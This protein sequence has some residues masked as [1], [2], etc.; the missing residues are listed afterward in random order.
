MRNS[1][2]KFQDPS[3]HSSKDTAGTK[4]CDKPTNKWME[5]PKG[6]CPINLFKFGR[7]TMTQIQQNGCQ[8]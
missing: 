7:I 8:E 6:I 3:M 4:T 2:L 5:K 1:Y